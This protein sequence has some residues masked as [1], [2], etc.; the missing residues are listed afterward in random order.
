[1]HQ[2]IGLT[3][4]ARSGKDSVAER[5]PYHAP[6][7]LADPIRRA[8]LTLDPLLPG[9]VR[10]SEALEAVNGDWNAL[11]EDPVLGDEVRRLP[12]AMGTEVGRNQI[13]QTLWLDKADERIG[14]LSPSPVVVTD[15]RFPDEARWLKDRGGLI[16]KVTRPGV[17]PANG[18]ISEAGIPEHMIDAHVLN[19]GTMDDLDA[20]IVLAVSELDAL[21]KVTSI[22]AAA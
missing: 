6:V 21:K 22:H 15:I 5:L 16:I 7:A 17:G 19:D 3:G 8:L 4:Y 14:W 2:L 12:Q 13:G 18:H 20:K 9:G 11:K 10:L 1:M